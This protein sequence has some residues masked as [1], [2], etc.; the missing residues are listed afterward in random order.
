MRDAIL[1]GILSVLLCFQSQ[2]Q[3]PNFVLIFCDDLSFL[4][5]EWMDQA[6]TPNLDALEASG[7]NFTNAHANVPICAP[8]RA[9][10]FNGLQA[11]SSG[12]YGHDQLQ[13][14]FS[15]HAGFSGVTTLFQHLRDN[16]YTV[17]AT[18]KIF[19]TIEDSHDYFSEYHDMNTFN[20]P[21]PW[22]GLDYRNDG[23]P[24]RNSHPST[25]ASVTA[26]GQGVASLAE[27]PSYPDYTG[28]LLGPEPYMYT[29]DSVRDLM[30]DEKA[31]AYLCDLL[32]EEHEDPFFFTAGLYRPHSPFYV[33]QRYFDLYPLDQVDISQVKNYD[34]EGVSTSMISNNMSGMTGFRHFDD[35]TNASMDSADTDWWLKRNL[36]GYLASVSFIDDQIGKVMEGIVNSEYGAS[37]YLIVTSDHGLHVGRRNSMGKNL[38]WSASTQIPFIVAGPGVPTEVTD[39]RP[40]SLVD[41]YPTLVDMAQVGPP[42]HTLDGHSLKEIIYA[43]ETGV[44]EGPDHAISAIGAHDDTPLF[45]PSDIQN[46]HYSIV[47]STYRFILLSSGE[48]ELYDRI[49]DPK[50]QQNLTNDPAY[51]SVKEDLKSRLMNEVGLSIDRS[52][53]I[54]TLDAFFYGDFE[55]GLNAWTPLLKE[56]STAT[57]STVDDGTNSGNKELLVHVQSL[58][59]DN[60]SNVQLVNSC[61]SMD[62]DK[63]Y[64]LSFKARS[65]T[66]GELKIFLKRNGNPDYNELA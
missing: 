12:F 63:D 4:G 5:S 49:N 29:N 24:V 1:T 23:S 39:D 52:M 62:H 7:V 44:W 59:D 26:T 14:E 60:S 18:G 41:L 43:P 3:S 46:Q 13:N 54:D 56:G 22:N 33:P 6:I 10:V 55:L 65:A 57:Y 58:L 51:Q 27:I 61:L 17:N 35:F 30:T 20:G 66:P 25:P 36:Q 47:D 28:W 45:T 21:Y 31:V 40:I 48:T 15:Q 53:A 32:A 19:H 38:L 37:T 8:S 11:Y 64:R 34:L 16:G 50:E 42:S 9:S 2:A